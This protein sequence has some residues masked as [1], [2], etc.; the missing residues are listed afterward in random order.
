MDSPELKY[1]NL[2]N[3]LKALGR[4]LIAFSGG[5]DST[6]LLKVAKD[7]L[8]D[9]VLAVTVSSET[10]PRCEQQDA[11]CFAKAS[12]AEHLL[13]KSHEMDLPEFVKNPLDR[14]YICKKSRFSDL[15]KLAHE[16]G[17]PYVADGENHD[18]QSDYRPGSRAAQ[19]LGIRSPLKAAGLTKAE[20]RLL[21][22]K[23]NL[24]T[25]DKPAYACLASRIP[26]HSPITAEKLRQVDEAE[27]FLRGLG[28]SPQLR[29]R[30]YNDTARIECEPKDIPKIAEST[31]RSHIVTHFK[32]L[33]FK[34][35]TLDLE[36]YH[37]GSLNP[38]R[39]SV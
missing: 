22:K 25:W 5:V 9:D 4:V 18:D 8:G 23:L 26:Y 35:I 39:S 33:R 31:L 36:G 2:Q 37:M 21:S 1:Q 38:D 12:D 34:F 14:C 6:L 32:S 28:L 17:F 29:V 30:H 11:I 13:V 27:E 20:I 10:T 24:P 19:E 15:L 3:I 7:I 16:K